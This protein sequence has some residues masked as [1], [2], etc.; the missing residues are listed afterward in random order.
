MAQRVSPIPKCRALDMPDME[1]MEPSLGS[2]LF[3]TSS[4]CVVSDTPSADGV[5]ALAVVAAVNGELAVATTTE[6]V[7]SISGIPFIPVMS[8]ATASG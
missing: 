4:R 8:I 3:V 6:F 2:S 1:A 7:V 5:W